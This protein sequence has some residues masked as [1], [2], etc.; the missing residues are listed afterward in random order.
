MEETKRKVS[1]DIIEKHV[2]DIME[3][4]GIEMTPST[5]GTPRRVAKMF[6]DEI[7]SSVGNNNIEEL[8]NKMKVFPLD[9]INNKELIIVKDVP[10]YSTCEH[11][12]MPFS[13]KISIGYVPSD[14]IIG[15]SKIPRV[16]KYFSKKP[17]VQERLI[18]EI[19]DYL[20]NRLHPEA[21][22]VYAF[23]TTHT[24]VTAR[25]IETY[26]ST[27]TLTSRGN[28]VNKYKNQFL[29]MINK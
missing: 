29:K 16:V 4:I 26:C 14:C 25:G 7:F 9:G 21:I 2:K 20:D 17:Q 13:G 3:L 19:I 11:H 18:E 22:F 8:D 6:V 28:K 5:E 12:L 27:D 15:L 23:D 1:K 10:F 24:C